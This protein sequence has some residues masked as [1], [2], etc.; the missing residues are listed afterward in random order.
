M[1]KENGVF[2]IKELNENFT[3]KVSCQYLLWYAC[4]LIHTYLLFLLNS[5]VNHTKNV[6]QLVSCI[7]FTLHIVKILRYVHRKMWLIRDGDGG[8]RVKAEGASLLG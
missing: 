4:E 5:F 6:K 1:N 8:E 2:Q 7:F 3:H